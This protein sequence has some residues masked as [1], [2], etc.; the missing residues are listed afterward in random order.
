MNI[1]PIVKE[2]PPAM[3]P[4]A[5]TSKGSGFLKVVSTLFRAKGAAD[6]ARLNAISDGVF[7]I[8]ITLMVFEIKIPDIPPGQAATELTPGLI[9][10]L[11]DFSIMLLSFVILGI[12]WV[13]HNNVFLHVLHHDRLLLWLNILF[14]LTVALIPFPAALLVRYGDEQIS[15]ILYALNLAIG[16]ALLDLIWTY[17]TYNRHLMCDSIQPDLVHS[18]HVR[19]LTGPVIYLVAIGVSFFSL[20][21]AKILFGVAIVYY[22][23]PTV[24][25]LLHHEQLSN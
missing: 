4:E 11:P 20:L 16:G 5:P 6:N 12:Y 7:A 8:V 19:I 25:D 9:K 14:L 22:L 21:A 1:E 13:G 3:T 15:V 2:N 17:A 10:L 23:I 24:Q 18:F